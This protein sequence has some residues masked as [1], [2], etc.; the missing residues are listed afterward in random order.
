LLV[1]FFII[2]IS[3]LLVTSSH[4]E[5]LKKRILLVGDSHTAGTFGRGS[6][7]DVTVKGLHLSLMERF[8]HHKVFTYGNGGA[9]PYN[10]FEKDVYLKYGYV[11]IDHKNRRKRRTGMQLVPKINKLLAKHRPEIVIVAHGENLMPMSARAA[12][13]DRDRIIRGAVDKMAQTIIQTGAKCIWIGPPS[14]CSRSKKP[15][16][17]MDSLK[18]AALKNGCHYFDGRPYTKKDDGLKDCLHYN[19]PNEKR[20]VNHWLKTLG[21]WNLFRK[22]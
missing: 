5:R 2:L 9:N 10:Y 13:K 18:D 14:S 20:W 1:R 4:A 6:T 16:H 15:E 21:T 19:T 8:P 7:K 3:V 22:H 12:A 11:Y 17:W